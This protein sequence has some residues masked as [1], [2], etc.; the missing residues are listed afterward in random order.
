MTVLTVIAV[1]VVYALGAMASAVV[2]GSK[3][4]GEEELLL[5]LLW[6][7]LLPVA[8]LLASARLVLEPMRRLGA[9]RRS[10]S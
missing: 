10:R 5:V 3:G 6:P 9:R 7:F 4:V 2:A 8:F 1:L